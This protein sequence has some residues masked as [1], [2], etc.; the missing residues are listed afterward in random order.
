M[1][2]GSAAR[3]AS[4]LIAVRAQRRCDDA[5]EVFDPR[6][7]ETETL[8]MAT[9]AS[10]SPTTVREF[11]LRVV[12]SPRLE[13]KLRPPPPDLP[14]TNRGPALRLERPA[15]TRDLRIVHV[16]E[17]RVPKIQGMLD[18]KQ[19]VRIVHAFCHH[20]LQAAELCAWALLAFPD[21]PDAFRRG[22]VRVLVDEQIHTRLYMQRLEAMGARLGDYP[23]SAY[24]WNK[25]G[26]VASPA[27]FVAALSLTFENANLDHA[28]TYAAWARRAGDE[29]LALLLDRIYAD[30]IHHVRFGWRWLARFKDP[31]ES[32]W[33]A[34]TR[35]L[36]P[37]LHPGRARGRE[38]R[39]EGRL[40]VGMDPEF[41]ERLAEA[42]VTLGRRR[43][44]RGAPCD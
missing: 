33:E 1:P 25:I 10:R 22:L 21:A 35:R 16:H 36:P 19:R 7:R 6:D 31:H 26:G 15:R 8:P 27:H 34:W 43:G 40:A 44:E 38:F 24:F 5:S 9:A 13:D 18:P 23:V 20:E 32:M 42:P 28:P 39:P 2:G 29:P 17:A 14:D 4:R 37:P 11:A 41:V 30:E 3:P 12:T